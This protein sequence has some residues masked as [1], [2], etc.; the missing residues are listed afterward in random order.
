MPI[1]RAACQR[2]PRS[3]RHAPGDPV[4]IERAAIRQNR[5]EGHRTTAPRPLPG[6]SSARRR[7]AASGGGSAARVDGRRYLV[8]PRLA[9]G[10]E[11]LIEHGMA[12]SHIAA[13]LDDEIG[14]F[15]ILVAAGH[16][17][18]AES[19]HVTRDGRRHA[20]PRIGVDIRRADEALHQ[21]VG[22]VIILSEQLT[23]DI[24]GDRIRP[25]RR[26]DTR[27]M[28]AAMKSSASSQPV[29]RG[30]AASAW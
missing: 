14:L 19:A 13:D 22:D 16:H 1:R 25:M 9:R 17:I 24:E 28:R 12:P 20:E 6:A 15:Q 23:G 18:L 7:S 4:M 3:R 29:A 10:H 2:S 5:P 8:P 30:R 21:F 11:A 27:R 26:A